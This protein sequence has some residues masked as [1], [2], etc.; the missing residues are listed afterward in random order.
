MVRDLLRPGPRARRGLF[1]SC[2]CTSAGL[3]LL[4]S[5]ADAWGGPTFGSSFGGSILMPDRALG[6]VIGPRSPTRGFAT[7]W[8]P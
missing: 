4:E 1:E 7:G 2:L 3:S 6:R 5:R 8:Y